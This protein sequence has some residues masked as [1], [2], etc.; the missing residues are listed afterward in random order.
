MYSTGIVLVIFV[1][2]RYCCFPRARYRYFCGRWY[3]TS[4][5]VF[6]VYITVIVV[7]LGTVPL[8]LWFLYST[9]MVVVILLQYLYCCSPCVQYRSCFVVVYN[10]GIFVVLV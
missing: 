2:Y 9:G 8:M 10:T 5:F 1:Q 7:V 4:I 3:R 6:P